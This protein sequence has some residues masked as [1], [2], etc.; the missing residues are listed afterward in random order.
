MNK[1]QEGIVI[2]I[3]GSLARVKT[4]RHN[5]CENC[6]ACPG[7]TA[8]VLEAANPE[9]A[10]PG[11]RVLVEVRE[12]NMLKAAFVVY[13]LPLVAAFAGAAGGGRAAEMAGMATFWPQAG[14]GVALFV[15]AILYIRHFDRSARTDS[16]M[17]P[18]I[19]RILRD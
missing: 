5:D 19:V 14:G 15:L 13:V 18:T 6:G 9:G 12:T 8:L 4:S 1:L 2:A 10:R 17:Q 7:N 16:K 11:Q 3:D